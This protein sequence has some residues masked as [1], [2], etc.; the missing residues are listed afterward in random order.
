ML[1]SCMKWSC[2]ILW[3]FGGTMLHR[4]AFMKHGFAVWSTFCAC[5]LCSSSI[6][7]YEAH[8]RCMKRSLTASCFF[9]RNLGKKM[10]GVRGFEPPASASRTQRSSQAEPH[11]DRCT[12]FLHCS[13]N[14]PWFYVFSSAYPNFFTDILHRSLIKNNGRRLPAC[15]TRHWRTSHP[16]VFAQSS[17]PTSRLHHPVLNAV[18]S[19][20]T[21]GSDP[22]FFCTKIEVIQ[23]GTQN[24][25]KKTVLRRF[26]TELCRKIRK[27][28]RRNWK[29]PELHLLLS[30][31]Q[32]Q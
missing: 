17:A 28:E 24:P 2:F 11:P 20:S 27:T 10:V 14:I 13:I 22:R 8:L 15:K 19:S 16:P 7:I 1:H 12:N 3:S 9:A 29:R 4:Q 30:V 25:G 31:Q 6:K 18:L 26:V 21:A 5:E 23:E 32:K